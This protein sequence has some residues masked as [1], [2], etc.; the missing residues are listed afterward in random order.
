MSGH[1]F[2]IDYRRF[3]IGL[4]AV[5][6][7]CVVFMVVGVAVIQDPGRTQVLSDGRTVS[8]GK[9]WPGAFDGCVTDVKRSVLPNCYREKVA[10][11]SIVKQPASSY[12][13]LTFCVIGVLLLL[14]V[15]IERANDTPEHEFGRFYAEWLAFVAILMGPGSIL[16]HAT[17]TNWGGWFDELSMYL[18]LGFMSGYGLTRWLQRGRGT[19]VAFYLGFFALAAVLTVLIGL[20]AFISMGVLVFAFEAVLVYVL[21]A[22]VELA[23][24]R[25]RFWVVVGTLG[26]AL[27]PWLASNPALGDPTGFPFHMLWHIISAVFVGAYFWYLRSERPLAQPGL[28][29]RAVELLGT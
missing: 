16:F 20:I 26:V 13:A 23:R 17:L 25:V 1:S 19:F 6:L 28:Q 27:V 8:V 5:I 29:P 9:S 11:S 12:S 4:G 24:D 7:F 3:L 18:L 2:W 22:R 14:L 15:G 10:E 21:L